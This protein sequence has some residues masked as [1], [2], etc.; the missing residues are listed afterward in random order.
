VFRLSVSFPFQDI[1]SFLVFSVP[2]D[3]KDGSFFAIGAWMT[4]VSELS[5]DYPSDSGAPDD[6]TAGDDE[7]SCAG[8]PQSRPVTMDMS[9]SGE[10]EAPVEPSPAPLNPILLVVIQLVNA[11]VSKLGLLDDSEFAQRDHTADVS[12]EY[13]IHNNGHKRLGEAEM[14][15]H[16]QKMTHLHRITMVVT[17]RHRIA[18]REMCCEERMRWMK[19]KRQS[20]ALEAVRTKVRFESEKAARE[21]TRNEKRESDR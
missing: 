14:T 13:D 20:D 18:S 7:G 8:L 21:A 5:D 11:A 15:R 9:R 6:S 10:V 12:D 4:G 1:S 16:Q 3:G 19:S 17:R 2:P